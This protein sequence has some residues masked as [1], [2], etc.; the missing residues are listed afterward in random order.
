M[1]IVVESKKI[2]TKLT[3]A[4]LFVPAYLIAS[5]WFLKGCE[6]PLNFVQ[7]TLQ[8]MLLF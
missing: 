5:F 6:S 4:K 2:T 8:E 1:E 7:L 3:V